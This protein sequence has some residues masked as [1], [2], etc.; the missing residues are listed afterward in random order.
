MSSSL[1]S[2]LSGLSAHQQW[3]DVIGNN[4]ANS[5]TTGYKSTRATFSS[6]FA[7]TLRFG[8]APTGNVGGTNPLQV[9]LGVAFGSI[10][11]S[12]SQGALTNTGRIFSSKKSSCSP[13]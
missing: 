2:A 11:R 12:F 10:D 5:N 4:I 1:F 6:A 13:A 9:G 3:I 8:S 7:Q